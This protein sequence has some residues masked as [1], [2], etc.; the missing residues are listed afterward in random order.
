MAAFLLTVLAVCR[1]SH[2]RS[3]RHM[4]AG[5]VT[6]I[7]TL[8][9]VIVGGFVTGGVEWWTTRVAQK[10]EVRA[11]RRLV[12]TELSIAM[13]GISH[14]VDLDDDNAITKEIQD[15]SGRGMITYRAWQ[16]Y[17]PLLARE[18]DE[19]AW[20]AI[21]DAYMPLILLTQNLDQPGVAAT[22]RDLIVKP[23]VYAALCAIRPELDEG[24][25]PEEMA[26]AEAKRLGIPP[27][28]APSTD[29]PSVT[30]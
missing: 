23:D 1:V 5:I 29:S 19:K 7:F 30:G 14:A 11:A 2:G 27:P 21:D 9:G 26:A 13:A 28:D 3:L 18:L 8:A 20:D 22:M 17:R 10:A 15:L 25:T 12:Y 24:T 4:D 6:G 16:E